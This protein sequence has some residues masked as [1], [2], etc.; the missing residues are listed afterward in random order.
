MVL[1]TL[2][3]PLMKDYVSKEYRD[4]VVNHLLNVQLIELSEIMKYFHDEDLLKS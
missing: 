4:Q 3:F 2:I 1:A